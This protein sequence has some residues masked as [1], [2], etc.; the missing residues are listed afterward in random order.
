MRK[1][2]LRAASAVIVFASFAL[3]LRSHAAG[4]YTPDMGAKSLGKGG[5]DI[6][7]PTSL[8]AIY[9]NPG[10]LANLQGFNALVDLRAYS[11]QVHFQRSGTYSGT[12]YAEVSNTGGALLAPAVG[13]SY[14]FKLGIPV[15]IAFG[16]TPPSGYSGDRYNDFFKIREGLGSSHSNDR[17]AAVK[18]PQR[19]QEISQGTR[20]FMLDL[21][22]SAK[23]LPILSVGAQI[24]VPIYSFKTSQALYLGS[25]GENGGFDAILNIEAKNGLQASGLLGATLTLPAGFHVGAAVQLPTPVRASGTMKITIPDTS[26]LRD[27]ASVTVKGD[28]ADLAID[29]PLVARLGVS[30]EQPLFSVELAGVYEAW[31]MYK[32][33]TLT[34]HDITITQTSREG[35]D[36]VKTV[37]PQGGAIKIMTGMVDAGS[38]RLGGELR[39]GELAQS[40]KWLKVRAGLIYETSAVPLDYTA[41]NASNWE[42]FIPTVGL[43]GSFGPIDVDLSYAHVFQPNRTVTNGKAPVSR[44]NE[45]SPAANNGDYEV[46]INLIGLSVGGHFG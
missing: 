37:P 40:A 45:G 20:G 15:A 31:S 22:L 39:V 9:Y 2:F 11:N 12:P 1:P 17:L 6:A 25:S 33:I 46:N 10:A 32:A 42:R 35:V 21:S 29:L 3:P 7:N 34:P 27:L 30:Y 13:L 8:T 41:V 5:A 14:G 24:Q 44:T 36:T 18:S 26:S 23:V 16:F 43:G 19:Y 28:K 4:I 38:I